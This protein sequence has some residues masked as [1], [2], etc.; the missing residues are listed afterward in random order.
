M[1][2]P[3]LFR[4]FGLFVAPRTLDASLC[5]ELR[6]EMR[7]ASGE[8]ARVWDG[9]RYEVDESL[10]RTTS[11]MPPPAARRAAEARLHALRPALEEH[12]RVSLT[13]CQPLQ[14]LHYREGDYYRRHPDRD[15]TANAAR[16][17]G[18]RRVSLVAFLNGEA[19]EPT[20]GSYSG[21]AL[22]FYGLSK[23]PGAAHVGLPLNGEEGLVVAFVP[24]LVHE[25]AVVT[26]G[27]RFTIG[28]WFC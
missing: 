10:R 11:V 24:E 2:P 15:A 21:G 13:G 12:F 8:K 7:R 26:A 1:A 23:S 28:T 3:F 19:S 20:D 18:E 16:T 14:F 17:P 27:E 6:E 5:A 22:V 9:G 4:S 25:V